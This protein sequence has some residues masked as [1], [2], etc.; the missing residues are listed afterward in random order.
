MNNS[1][2]YSHPKLPADVIDLLVIPSSYRE[3]ID[4]H[5]PFRTLRLL[6]STL[7]SQRTRKSSD[8]FSVQENSKRILEQFINT[9]EY[10]IS[11]ADILGNHGI[12]ENEIRDLLFE[13][14]S[15]VQILQRIFDVYRSVTPRK[16][17]YY[18][19]VSSAE[20]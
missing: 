11:L 13:W 6:D 14:D 15:Y 20:I 2:Y 3:V 1:Y 5:T 18:P 19:E 16:I 8:L 9:T 17:K 10:R 4:N 12:P 7:I